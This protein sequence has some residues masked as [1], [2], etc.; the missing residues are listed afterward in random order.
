[1]S[2][3]DIFKRKPA[4]S[5]M[6]KKD[7]TLFEESRDIADDNTDGQLSNSVR[8]IRYGTGMPIDIIYS[9][10]K[11]DYEQRGYDDAI[12]NPDVSYKKMNLSIIQSNL[13]IK[14]KQVI[15]KYENELRTINFHIESRF[16]AGLIDVVKQL[17]TRKICFCSIWKN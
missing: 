12:C 14:F 16:Q 9:Y 6:E 15:L 2:I 7:D 1:M 4:T 10:L 11:E 13:E 5:S 17:M 3:W 8:I